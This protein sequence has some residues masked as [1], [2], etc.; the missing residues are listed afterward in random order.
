MRTQRSGLNALH[1]ACSDEV[2]ACPP[3]HT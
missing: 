1:Y 2:A 3:A